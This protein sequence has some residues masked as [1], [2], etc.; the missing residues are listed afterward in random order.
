[1]ILM[2]SKIKEFVKINEGNII[3]ITGVVLVSLISFAVGYLVAREQFKE[4]I[5]IEQRY[6]EQ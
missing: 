2:L 5:R 6:G 3:L 4:P 1:M